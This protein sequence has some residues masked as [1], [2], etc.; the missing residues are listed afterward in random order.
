MEPDQLKHTVLHSLKWVAAGKIFTQL[1]RWVM[2]FWVIRLLTPEDYGLVA[3]ADV[4]FSLLLLIMG[5][6]FSPGIIQ[7]KEIDKLTISRLFG[8]VLLVHTTIFIVQYLSAGAIADYYQAEA[9]ETILQVNAWCFLILAFNVIPQAMLA[10][11]MQFKKVS[12]ISAIANISA[13]VTTLV[14]AIYDYGYWSLVIGEVVMITLK[15]VLMLV[16]SRVLVWPRFDLSAVADYMK[17]GGMLTVH[18]VLFYVF[19]HMDVFIAGRFLSAAEVG[20]FALGLQF[21]LMPQKKLLP[22]LRQVA[23]PAFSKIQES[24]S[25]VSHYVL[26]AQRLSLIVTIPVF[27][28]LASVV[29]LVIPIVLGEKWVEAIYPCMV[30][31]MVMPLRF[32]DE[33]FY[34]ALKSQ[35]RVKHM[36]TNVLFNITALSI[37]LFSFIHMGALGIAVAWAVS[38]PIAYMIVLI[39]NC[40]AL[41]VSVSS[42]LKILYPLLGTGL[43]MVGAVFGYKTYFPE[44]TLF[45]LMIQ[46]VIGAVTYVAALYVIKKTFF[47]ELLGLLRRAK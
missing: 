47:R 36:I 10:R 27:W 16:T 1:I 9:V 33:L 4:L 11:E 6:L 39:R 2:T 20:L 5:T 12:I 14:M 3:M 42:M 40:K 7:A 21:A 13:A 34:P 43:I 25:K 41:S 28:G 23:F 44:V 18:V 30:I 8:G 31:L 32:S 19:I 22:L 29:D 17:F 38:F 15:T 37:G 46:V 45:N 35:R 24:K 26:K